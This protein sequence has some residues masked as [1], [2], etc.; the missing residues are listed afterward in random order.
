[1]IFNT[2]LTHLGSEA[3]KFFCYHAN[4]PISLFFIHRFWNLSKNL[5][6]LNYVYLFIYKYSDNKILETWTKVFYLAIPIIS[7]NNQQNF[8]IAAIR[9]VKH[10]TY[11]SGTISTWLGSKFILRLMTDNLKAPV[12]GTCMTI[13]FS[14]MFIIHIW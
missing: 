13:D 12:V 3:S 4:L 1:M 7:F 10:L 2:G 9:S 6:A 8:C 14:T 11:M 5:F